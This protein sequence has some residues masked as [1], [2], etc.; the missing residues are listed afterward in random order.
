MPLPLHVVV[1][2]ATVLSVGCSASMGRASGG[3]PG[4]VP[5][6]QVGSVSV[7]VD[8]ASLSGHFFKEAIACAGR[9]FVLGTRAYFLVGVRTVGGSGL[10]AG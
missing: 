1:G 5:I 3:P 4:A 10:A 8:L 9:C 7:E 6:C 2:C